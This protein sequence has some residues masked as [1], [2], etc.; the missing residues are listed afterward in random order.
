[1]REDLYSADVLLSVLYDNSVL[2]CMRLAMNIKKTVM[3]EGSFK[4]ELL[5]N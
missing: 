1:M 4:F 2:K 5:L 3:Q